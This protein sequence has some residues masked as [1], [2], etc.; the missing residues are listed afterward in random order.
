MIHR[1]F[2]AERADGVRLYRTYSD[3]KKY[4]RKVGTEEVYSEAI[5]LESKGYVY[6]ETDKEIEE[7]DILASQKLEEL[8]E[9]IKAKGSTEILNNELHFLEVKLEMAN[10]R[11][12][13][14]IPYN[15]NYLNDAIGI[16]IDMCNINYDYDK[17]NISY[18]EKINTFL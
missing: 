4:I 18:K 1:E 2:Y 11:L 10:T 15:N 6:E 8:K 13:Q 17:P 7:F 9:Q 12:K 16:R 5:D 3:A 14:D